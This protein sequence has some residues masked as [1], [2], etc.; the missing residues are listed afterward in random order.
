M[1]ALAI[2]L[3]CTAGAVFAAEPPPAPATPTDAGNTSVRFDHPERFIDAGDNGI[4]SRTSPRVLAILKGHI[5]KLGA[6]YLAPGQHLEVTVRD[7]DLAGR[8]DPVAGHDDRVRIMRDVD[9]PRIT[10]HYRLTQG[11]QTLGDAD[12]TVSDIS[13]LRTGMPGDTDPLRYEKNMLDVWFAKT[14]GRKR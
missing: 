7:V 12:A 9:W 11:E 4:G 13:Y 2:V 8:F 1:R 5:E 14:F 3:L 10:L 6:K